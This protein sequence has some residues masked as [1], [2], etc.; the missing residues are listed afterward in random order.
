MSLPTPCLS[1]S[2]NGPIVALQHTFHQR[3]GRLIIEL[4]LGVTL[5]VDC[6][7]CESFVDA[8]LRVLNNLLVELPVSA[9]YACVLLLDFSVVQRTFAYYDLDCLRWHY[10]FEI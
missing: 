10:R 4:P 3:E 9:D 6:V 7:E 1:V 8:S 2:E 5:V